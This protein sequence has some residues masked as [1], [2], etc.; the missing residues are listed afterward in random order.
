MQEKKNTDKLSNYS[1][2]SKCFKSTATKSSSTNQYPDVFR[3]HQFQCSSDASQITVIFPEIDL[4]VAYRKGEQNMQ[5][6]IDTNG[7]KANGQITCPQDYE[8]FCNYIIIYP[9]FCS[10]KGVCVNGQCICQDRFG[11]VDC[12]IKCSGVVDNYNC[13]KGQCPQNKFLN[14]DNTCKSDCPSGSFDDAGKCES[15]D[16]NCSRCKGPSA[17]ECTR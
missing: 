8:R 16:N 4:Q 3:C 7:E 15:C 13:S 14:T 17:N 11:G 1:T 6:N 9:N 10:Q 12:S 5:K 2:Q